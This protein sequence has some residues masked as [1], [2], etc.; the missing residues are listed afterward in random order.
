MVIAIATL[1]CRG[2]GEDSTFSPSTQMQ[3]PWGKPLQ[4]FHHLSP[5]TLF[6]YLLRGA[7]GSALRKE[8]TQTTESISTF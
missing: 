6:A 2:D 5:A 4:P 7:C 1:H 3:M 8:L